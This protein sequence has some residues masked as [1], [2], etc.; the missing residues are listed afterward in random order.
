LPLVAALQFCVRDKFEWAW[1]GR[2]PFRSHF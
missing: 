1:G 2:W